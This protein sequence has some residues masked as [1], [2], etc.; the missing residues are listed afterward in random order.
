MVNEIK[1]I[2][3]LRGDDDVWLLELGFDSVLIFDLI[4]ALDSEH[5]RHLRR[6]APQDAKA[7]TELLLEYTGST[8]ETEVPD[9]YYGESHHFEYVLDLLEESMDSLTTKL[10]QQL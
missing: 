7:R 1:P 4:L 8:R 9:P 10:Q 3:T 6:M 2:I 5:M